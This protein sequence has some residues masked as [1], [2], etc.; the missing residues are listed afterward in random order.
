MRQFAAL[1]AL[2]TTGAVLGA[3]RLSATE[4]GSLLINIINNESIMTGPAEI[5]YRGSLEI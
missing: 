1:A 4:K 3:D 2:A 5:S